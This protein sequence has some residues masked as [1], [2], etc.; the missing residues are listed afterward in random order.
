MNDLNLVPPVEPTLTTQI[1]E[2]LTYQNQL[3]ATIIVGF[4]LSLLFSLIMFKGQFIKTNSILLIILGT[5]F[6]LIPFVGIPLY[7]VY[8]FIQSKYN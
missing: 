8:S 3:T 4:V 5:F 1:I 2:W 7:L 6:P